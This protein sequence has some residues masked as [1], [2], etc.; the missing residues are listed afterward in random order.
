MS[1]KEPLFLTNPLR[2]DCI[3]S[4]MKQTFATLLLLCSISFTT[5]V[6]ADDDTPLAEQMSAFNDAYKAMGKEADAAKGA[7]LAREA[8]TA[9]INSLV[10][11]PEAMDALFPDKAAA[12]KALALYKKMIGESLVIFCKV[13]IAFLEGKTEDIKKLLDEAKA[14]KKEGHNTFMEE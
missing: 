4:V 10:L 13:E 12:E 1:K 3:T 5:L 7:A 2:F 8:Q 11:K 6:R 14:L 9:M